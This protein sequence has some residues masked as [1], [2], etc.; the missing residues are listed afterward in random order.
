MLIKEI[1]NKEPEVVKDTPQTPTQAEISEPV[2]TETPT[3]E[4]KPTEPPQ[5]TKP[6]EEISA[7]VETVEQP[8]TQEIH[9]EIPEPVSK[10][11]TAQ[12]QPQPQIIEKIV[13][14]TDPNII[15]KLLTKARAKIQ[16]RK[17]V[18]LNKIMSFFVLKPQITNKDVQK[19]LHARKRTVTRYLEQLEQEQKIIQIG[20]IGKGV[21][22]TKKQ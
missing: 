20:K 21:F 14:T 15:Q 7:P 11:E 8:A 1:Q 2:I 16:E 10:P 6:V 22:Y 18:K 3:E 12:N 4:T 13:Y 19:L 9:E 5:E 17:R